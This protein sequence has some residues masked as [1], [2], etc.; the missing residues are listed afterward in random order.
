[1]VQKSL[2]DSSFDHFSRIVI[3]KFSRLGN[4]V[5]TV[6]SL[7]SGD[8]SSSLSKT[9]SISRSKSSLISMESK[10]PSRQTSDVSIRSEHS[11]S[12]SA[13]H[14]PVIKQ[15][16]HPQSKYQLL[17][18]LRLASSFRAAAKVRPR[19]IRTSRRAAAPLAQ[20]NKYVIQGMVQ[21]L[22]ISILRTY[23]ISL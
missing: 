21:E 10:G 17:A 3:N 18:N 13:T 6:A 5:S 16:L 8:F 7:L 19:L 4:D 14:R 1:M 20:A 2:R 23:A 11:Q 9:G 12:H 15:P 22:M